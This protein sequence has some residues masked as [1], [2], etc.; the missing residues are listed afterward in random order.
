MS[1]MGSLFLLSY[2]PLFTQVRGIGILR[3][4]HS[5]GPMLRGVL[6]YR[7]VELLVVHMKH[8]TPR[9]MTIPPAI[10]I[11]SGRRLC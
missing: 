3:S 10:L 9:N 7:T 4:S 2:L 1:K 6:M 5:P 11:P 8:N